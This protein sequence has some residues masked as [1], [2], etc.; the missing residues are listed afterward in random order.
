MLQLKVKDL[1]GDVTIGKDHFQ[2]T[3]LE[4]CKALWAKV[5]DPLMSEF[6]R[7]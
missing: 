1:L 4:S 5:K 3:L 7:V 2:G 6:L